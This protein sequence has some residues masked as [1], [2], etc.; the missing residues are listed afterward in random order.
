MITLP[1]RLEIAEAADL[2]AEMQAALQTGAALQVDGSAVASA[3]TAGLQL[4]I[5]L[6]HSAERA[7]RQ[8]EWTA[9]STHLRAAAAGLGL[10]WLFPPSETPDTDTK[11]ED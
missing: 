11:T 7:G 10:D 6:Q 8:I 3:D 9:L 1:A 5:S 2:Q 4:L